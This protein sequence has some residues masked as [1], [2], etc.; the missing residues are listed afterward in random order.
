MNQMFLSS[1][2][3]GDSS[4]PPSYVQLPENRPGKV[5]SSSHEAIPVIDL[6]GGDRA[7]ITQQILKASEEYGFF[8]VINHGVSQ[9]LM[10]QTLNIFKEFHAMPPQDKV[11]ECSKDPEGSFKIY[12]SGEN[13]KKISIHFWK[14]SLVH[15]C[16]PSGE[17]LHYWPQKP[18]NYREIVGSY[19]REM[20]KLSL[21]ILEI[22]CEGLG[23][24]ARH[25]DPTII[26]I[27]LQDKEVEGLQV[28]KNG[29]WIGVYPIPNAFVVNI[30]LLLQI[31]SNGRLVGVE[32]RAVTNSRIARTSVVYFVYPSFE[33]IIEPAQALIKGNNTQPIYKSI[34]CREFRTNFYQKGPKVRVLR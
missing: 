21:E 13:Y 34:T 28:L 11:N 32:H 7:H 14:D 24:E 15:P 4:V 29:E 23:L 1:W 27:L 6:G 3:N 2:N 20:N 33:S 8:Q 22:M 19:T 16:P 10:D 25:R 31:I 17:N 30:G 5:L 9:D 12:T 18:S 26:T